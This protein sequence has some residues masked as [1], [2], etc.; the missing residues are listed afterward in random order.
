MVGFDQEEVAP[1]TTTSM[2]TKKKELLSV[3]MMRTSEW[4]VFYP[5]PSFICFTTSCLCGFRNLDSSLYIG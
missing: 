5:I 1:P 4:F 2:A 3:A